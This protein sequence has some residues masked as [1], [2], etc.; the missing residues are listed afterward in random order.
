MSELWIVLKRS[1]KEAQD[2]GIT[3]T[4]QALAYSLFLAIPSMLLVVLGVFS[5]VANPSDVQRLVDRLGSGMAARAAAPLGARP[6]R[7]TP[8]ARTRRSPALIGVPLPPG[9]A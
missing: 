8:S 7:S 6:E 4:A 9:A 5:L 2:D 1:V 3:T